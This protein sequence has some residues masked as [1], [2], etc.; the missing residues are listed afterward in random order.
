MPA[1]V[2]KHSKAHDGHR[3]PHWHIISPEKG[4]VGH[5]SS[6]A[7]AKTSARI[8]TERSKK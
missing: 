4:V 1:I 2:R 3:D 5:S 6:Q 7:K 8:R